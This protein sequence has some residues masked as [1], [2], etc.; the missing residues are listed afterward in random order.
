VNRR[1]FLGSVLGALVAPSL[2][3]IRRPTFREIVKYRWVRV[4][5]VPIGK[6]LDKGDLL[7]DYEVRLY[8]KETYIDYEEEK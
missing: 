8:E 1:S 3:D 6:W 7:P 4:V 2:P 5:A